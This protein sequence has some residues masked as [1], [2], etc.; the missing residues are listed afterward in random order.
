MNNPAILIDTPS[1][2]VAKGST[3]NVVLSIESNLRFKS[4]NMAL[5][6]DPR[7]IELKSVNSINC[8]ID[9]SDKSFN[10]GIVP[11]NLSDVISKIGVIKCANIQFVAIG[12]A[13]TSSDVKVDLFSINY[14]DDS[15][16]GGISGKERII[17]SPNPFQHT[18]TSL[19]D[20][21]VGHRYLYKLTA[22]GGVPPYKWTGL[23]IPDEFNIKSN[24]ILTGIPRTL[25]A[26]GFE[27]ELKDSND[28]PSSIIDS[29]RLE[30]ITE[31]MSLP[32]NI[33]ED[34][35]LGQPYNGQLNVYGG[36][37]PYHW[38][39]KSGRLPQGIK[40][41]EQ[42]IL[43]GICAEVG[44]YDLKIVVDDSEGSHDESDIKIKAVALFNQMNSG[45][46]EGA[47][48]IIAL[49]NLIYQPYDITL[50][51]DFETGDIQVSSMELASEVFVDDISI[52]KGN[53]KHGQNTFSE[54][55]L[56][57]GPRVI[58]VLID[59]NETGKGALKFREIVVA[60]SYFH[61]TPESDP[62][63]V[64]FVE[65]DKNT[66]A[67]ISETKKV[68]PGE[69]L[70]ADIMMPGS[71]DDI[72]VARK[73]GIE[74]LTNNNGKLIPVKAFDISGINNL[75][76]IVEGGTGNH[77]I[78]S[79]MENKKEIGLLRQDMGGGWSFKSIGIGKE[80]TSFEPVYN[81]Y[82]SLK[83][84][85]GTKEG[86]KLIDLEMGIEK[87][88]FETCGAAGLDEVSD[89]CKLDNSG[90]NLV[91]ANK[92]GNNVVFL[93]DFD[94]TSTKVR[95]SV[96]DIGQPSKVD[97]K[98]IPQKNK[99][100][101][102]VA[103]RTKNVVKIL[104]IDGNNLHELQETR[105]GAH[106]S[107]LIMADFGGDGNP[108]VLTA[109]AISNTI[110]VTTLSEK[111]ESTAD[112]HFGP[113][114]PSISIAR[115]V[116][117]RLRVFALGKES[118]EIMSWL[119]Y[120]YCPMCQVT[121]SQ[122]NKMHLKK[123]QSFIIEKG[124][125]IG[126]SGIADLKIYNIEVKG[127]ERHCILLNLPNFPINLKPDTSLP[128]DLIYIGLDART[129]R[130]SIEVSTNDPLYP[131][132]NIP[133]TVNTDNIESPVQQQPI[134]L[135]F[136]EV[137]KG[138]E[139][140][141]RW[142]LGNVLN[143][144]V[145]IKKIEIIGN[146]SKLFKLNPQSFPIYF[147]EGI[148]EFEIIADTNNFS[149]YKYGNYKAAII[150]EI[151]ADN[152][153]YIIASGISM[154]IIRNDP[155]IKLIYSKLYIGDAKLGEYKE[156]NISIQNNGFSELIITNGRISNNDKN[157]PDYD[158][159]E[160]VTSLPYSVLPGYARY[161][162]KIRYRPIRYS[163]QSQDKCSLVLDTNDPN[164]PHVS[165]ELLGTCRPC[166]IALM[167]DQMEFGSTL[168]DFDDIKSYLSKTATFYNWGAGGADIQLKN[169]V[170]NFEILNQNIFP[171][172]QMYGEKSFSV[173]PKK[174]GITGEE[175]GYI[176]FKT[177]DPKNSV[178]K[179]NLKTTWYE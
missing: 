105:V 12:D 53:I 68:I 107:D 34:C 132:I 21:I 49:P 72:L 156:G 158:Q 54:C 164:S 97:S 123:Y 114:I 7:V 27:I 39:I 28:P 55:I 41:N 95:S 36:V 122:I 138:T 110:S 179:L 157:Y 31:P 85:V 160:V 84:L 159:F 106:P 14:N 38:N 176:E 112:I 125:I 62:V 141:L 133:I 56:P 148:I 128:L 80:Y 42:G 91:A 151:S 120:S 61:K 139:R 51:V 150:A 94:Y 135:N 116:N 29:L 73:D 102:A 37:P 124:I 78:M 59:K 48:S 65:Y 46:I 3:I 43:S 175:T 173:L 127:S 137:S 115:D 155:I 24:G 170:G 44:T 18:I 76:C 20:A 161:D 98:T 134:N 50:N 92:Y 171:V 4:A 22:K 57:N 174:T 166:N 109:D 118:G 52:F 9:T 136:G 149:N 86:V 6:F 79:E 121:P 74:L 130:C 11:L 19:P 83:A 168:K 131:K 93:S 163:T 101:V 82:K 142:Y 47:Q 40:L 140:K 143:K 165:I 104:E 126:N 32:E 10:S 177:N 58:K 1:Q 69:E 99:T 45:K 89:I 167:P 35:R 103:C 153:N 33:L 88:Q 67:I 5:I 87:E 145:Y 25:G 152:Q 147:K 13:G 113:E 75:K 16:S 172:K 26:K 90:L 119:S 77:L 30:V 81:G 129:I 144:E 66:N 96:K 108:S 17:I 15:K 178:I 111:P 71:S 60:P 63:K 169:I 117:G 70:L 100:Y 64:N 154:H 8:T 2:P 162:F 23:K 146:N